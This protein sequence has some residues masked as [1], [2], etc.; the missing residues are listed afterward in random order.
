MTT[1][2]SCFLL[3]VGMIGY[4]RL[5]VRELPDVDFP[6]VSVRTIYRGA[7]AQVVDEKVTDVIERQ[8]STLEGVKHITSSSRD[9]QSVVTI[10]FDLSRKI[11][12]AAQDVRDRIG[13]IRALLPRDVDEP[14][15]EKFDLNAFAIM[16]LA[17]S[18]KE[19]Y[20]RSELSL[21]AFAR[22]EVRDRLETLPGVGSILIG[23]EKRRAMRIEVD[24]NKL[25]S[26]GITYDEVKR[27][28]KKQNVELPTGRVEGVM[29]EYTLELKGRPQSSQEFEELIVAQAAD[30]SVRLRDVGRAYEGVE[31]LRTLARFNGKKAVGL[32]IIKQSQA[33]TIEV[34][35]AVKQEMER[36]ALPPDLQLEI[37]FDSSIFVRD[38]VDEVKTSLVLAG[39]LVLGIIY[40]FLGRTQITLIPAVVM[41]IS[42]ISTYA[43]M[44]ALGFTLN[45]FTLLALVLSIGVVVDDAIVILENSVRHLREKTGEQEARGPIVSESVSEVALAVVATS[46]ALI[47]VFLPIAFV[48]GQIGRFFYEFGVTVSVS[49]AIST[50]VALTLTPMLCA[51]LLSRSLL[52]LKGKIEP[53]ITALARRYERLLRFAMKRRDRVLSSILIASV[54][55]SALLFSIVGKEFIPTSDRGSFIVE[56]KAPQGATLYYGDRHLRQVE[57]LLAKHPGVA[58]F[59][60]ALALSEAGV[61]EVTKG[62]VFTRLHDLKTGKRASQEQILQE[63]RRNFEEIPGV[64]LSAVGMSPF[65]RGQS[66]KPFQL[67][68][69]CNDFDLLVSTARF[70]REALGTVEGLVDLSDD[71]RLSKP[72]FSLE[73]DRDFLWKQGVNIEQISSVLNAY[74]AGE[75]IGDYERRG[76]RFDLILQLP[77][78]RRMSPELLKA[79]DVRSAQGKLVN[80]ASLLSPKMGVGPSE[81]MRY[82]RKRSVTFSANIDGRPLGEISDRVTQLLNE[83]IPL[84]GAVSWKFKGDAEQM[85]ESLGSLFS[86]FFLSLLFIY[87]VLCA[88]FESFLDPLVI[89]V[90]VPLSLLGALGA[91]VVSGMALNIYSMIGMIMLIGLVTKNAILLIDYARVLRARGKELE[92]AIYESGLTRLRPIL[93]TAIS[94][95]FG[96]L[97]IALAV[98]AGAAE[99]RPL[100][101]AAIGGMLSATLLTLVVIPLVYL[102]LYRIKAWLQALVWSAKGVNES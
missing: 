36:I 27:A 35:D 65:S 34:A 89:M 1:V 52:R 37:A 85:Q 80:L 18:E 73:F 58:S 12:S 43:C 48:E 56:L 6:V 81:I 9:S 44:Y 49:I 93:M 90:C 77:A 96:I 84:D 74:L 20:E 69:S 40:L 92:E 62:V 64:E 97:P 19:G 2:F 31:N 55:L 33:N 60:S 32:G 79:I 53:M 75:Q 78:A 51:L 38:S 98:G 94:T 42:V 24:P 86:A 67:V 100:G 11:E 68:L 3:L 95:I 7:S 13:R 46:V 41:P 87:L 102:L 4:E 23:G 22:D 30:Q 91:L 15:V 70:L 10:E 47:A 28:L 83:K 16:W 14:S 101:V 17:L 82:D 63:L 54:A 29:R 76:E 72:Q 57:E 39:A 71:L 25:S 50:L 45:N 66:N 88:Q 61:G 21:S 59:F 8:I 5:S 26:Y 99:R